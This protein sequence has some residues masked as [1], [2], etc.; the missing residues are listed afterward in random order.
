M[1][2]DHETVWRVPCASN[3]RRSEEPTLAKVKP[4][5]ESFSYIRDGRCARAGVMDLEPRERGIAHVQDLLDP[6]TARSVA[7][8]DELRSQRVVVSRDRAEGLA[9]SRLAQGSAIRT[10][11]HDGHAELTGASLGGA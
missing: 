3:Q 10:L 9:Q 11:Q 4:N 8:T 2:G 1:D 5:E 6:A 7:S